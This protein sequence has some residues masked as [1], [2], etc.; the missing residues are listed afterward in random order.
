MKFQNIECGGLGA[1]HAFHR[2]PWFGIMTVFVFSHASREFA[3]SQLLNHH[4]AKMGKVCGKC[5]LCGLLVSDVES[6]YY[7]SME[8]SHWLSHRCQNQLNGHLNDENCSVVSTMTMGFAM[9]FRCN[10]TE[11]YVLNVILRYSISFLPNVDGVDWWIRRFLWKQYSHLTSR[12][13]CKDK[14]RIG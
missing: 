9:V 14:V 7:V 13:H 10:Q 4:R 12:R 1:Y 5:L 11:P 3:Y 8:N 6:V 2:R